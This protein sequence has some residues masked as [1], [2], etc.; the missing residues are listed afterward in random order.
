[1]GWAVYTAKKH[2][3]GFE[4]NRKEERESVGIISGGSPSDGNQSEWIT[5]RE[6][7]FPYEVISKA[8]NINVEKADASV[9]ADRV[10]IL[11]SIIGKSSAEIND[12]PPEEHPTYS[13]LNDS[14]KSIFA[15]SQASLQGAA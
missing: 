6:K 5:A 3:Y 2:T 15:A 12:S 11:N 4:C 7:H 1:M 13:E 9:D 14:L 10:H 8:L